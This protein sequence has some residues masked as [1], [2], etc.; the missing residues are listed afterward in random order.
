M[1]SCGDVSHFA[2]VEPT[3]SFIKIT[4]PQG[5]IFTTVCHRDAM[6]FFQTDSL[7][8]STVHQCQKHW[9]ELHS[10]VRTATVRDC[11][12]LKLVSF[13]KENILDWQIHL[14]AE[15]LPADKTMGAQQNIR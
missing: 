1:V 3:M 5:T 6:E 13:G 10:A 15:N 11:K 2:T 9:R 14:F 4:S 8:V 7:G 12:L